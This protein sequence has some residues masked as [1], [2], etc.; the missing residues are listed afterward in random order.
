MSRLLPSSRRLLHASSRRLYSTAP[1][2]PHKIAS[3]W[4][5][6][7]SATDPVTRTQYLDANQLHLFALTLNRP[8]DIPGVDI[9]NDAPPKGTPI[10]P[11][12]HWIYFTVPLLEKDL[13]IDG[14][15]ASYNPEAPFTR[16]MWAGGTLSWVGGEKN[17]LRVGQEVRETTRI[18]SADAKVT[19]RGEEMIVVG[20]EK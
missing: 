6:K 4:L 7:V 11:G 3:D 8:Q 20:L 5:A 12:Y 15:D 2:P 18:L 10:P 14:T 9:V 16:R 17:P 1:G 19:K 13:G